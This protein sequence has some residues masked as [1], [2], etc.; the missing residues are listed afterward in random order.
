MIWQDMVVSFAVSLFLVLLILYVAFRPSVVVLG[1]FV[2]TLFAALAW[3]L[4]LAYSSTGRST[5]S[6]ASPPRC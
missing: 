6:P 2:V 4:L 5:S 3:T 1:I